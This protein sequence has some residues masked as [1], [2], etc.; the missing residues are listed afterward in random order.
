[1]NEEDV[2]NKIVVPFLRELGFHESELYFEF[3]FTLKFGKRNIWIGKPNKRSAKHAKCDILVKRNNENLFIVELK[4]D[5][6]T[7][8]QEDRDQAWSY[9]RLVFP[10]VPLFIVTNG[11]DFKLF[12]SNTKKEIRIQD[13]KVEDKY[14]V[15]LIEE[16]Y[17]EALKYFIGYSEDNLYAFC[18]WQVNDY[19]SVLKGASDD[20]DKKYIPELYE[21]A[22][23][24]EEVFYDFLNSKKNTFAL[25]GE[26]GQGKTCWICDTAL[27]FIEKN[28]PVLFYRSKDIQNGIFHILCEDLNWQLQPQLE[29]AKAS[30]R[31]FDIFSKHDKPVLIFI[32]GLDEIDT[33]NARTTIDNFLKRIKGYNCRLITTCKSI[34]WYNF[35]ACDGVPTVLSQELYEYGKEKCYEIKEI[36]DQQLYNIRKKYSEFYNFR[37]LIQNELLKACRRNLFFLRVAFEAASQMKLQYLSY[38]TREIFQKY[39]ESIIGRFDSQ[40]TETVSSILLGVAKALLEENSDN[41][42]SAKLKT[43]LGMSRAETIPEKLF[44][45]GILERIRGDFSC[46]VG[47]YFSKLRDY[48]IAFGVLQF[49]KLTPEK[50]SDNLNELIPKAEIKSSF[51]MPGLPVSQVEKNVHYEVISF[52]YL[53]AS[54]E[55]K[56]VLDRGLYEKALEYVKFYEE[57]LNNNFPSLKRIFPPGTDDEIGFVGHIDFTRQVIF[58]YG[59]RKLD[60]ELEKV[61]L[62]PGT[63]AERSKNDNLIYIKGVTSWRNSG[64]SKGF[65][66][67]NIEKEV[68]QNEVLSELK[69]IISKGLLNEDNNKELLIERLAAIVSKRYPDCF[70]NRNDINLDTLKRIVFYKII[71]RHLT[72]ND[73]TDT[74]SDEE[75]N[76]II[77]DNLIL[78]NNLNLEQFEK[79]TKFIITDIEKFALKDIEKL[80]SLHLKEIPKNRW[81]NWDA[82]AEKDIVLNNMERI[83]KSFLNQYKRLVETNFPTLC[84]HFNLYKKLP[85]KVFV[86]MDADT[87]V[88]SVYYCDK[89]YCRDDTCSITVLYSDEI[90]KID[91]DDKILLKDG[92]EY[93]CNMLCSSNIDSMFMMAEIRTYMPFEVDKYKMKIRNLIYYKIENE[94][95]SAFNEFL[96][97]EVLNNVA[98]Q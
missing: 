51:V 74:L 16:H 28:Y 90:I 6:V 55:H 76:K 68:I 70:M 66:D 39:Y 42:D 7:I 60:E 92:S 8:S 63:M 23:E 26:S 29:E 37:G 83:C 20:R 73:S 97:K 17:Y 96:Q 52:Y 54:P 44:E 89:N 9:A 85:C 12:D 69:E 11:K 30:K 40:E 65:K 32:D 41:I 49:D 4:S 58:D 80:K 27:A 77:G 15:T 2:K 75:Q 38:T 67:I 33:S 93:S 82:N 14:S 19:M 88:V 43:Y 86:C 71:H 1:M 31:F 81:S 3:T 24:L 22:K 10:P 47:F 13:F 34:A 84:Q 57:F 25:K 48:L 61:L 72:G 21:K 50:F 98:I 91:N 18:S 64:T 59:F 95:E 94:V 45:R 35:I 53:L 36:D 56:R 87:G 62:L 46:S 78:A 5:Q 79:E